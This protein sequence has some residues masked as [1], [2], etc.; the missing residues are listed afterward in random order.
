MRKGI[1]SL[2]IAHLVSDTFGGGA[3]AILEGSAAINTIG[4]VI[5][6]ELHEEADHGSDQKSS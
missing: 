4:E 1:G 6:A 3:E 2:Q 5:D